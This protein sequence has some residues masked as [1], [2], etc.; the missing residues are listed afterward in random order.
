MNRI[1]K[2]LHAE[3]EAAG[4]KPETPEFDREERSRR[5]Q[6][7]RDAKAIASCWDCEYFD[8]CDLIK[9]HL[10]DV[11]GIKPEKEGPSGKPPTTRT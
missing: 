10:R 2:K 3:L 8:H 6:M 5:V 7:C 11:Y 1:L 4:L 9:S